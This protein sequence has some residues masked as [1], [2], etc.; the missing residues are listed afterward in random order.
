MDDRG[1]VVVAIVATGIVVAIVVGTVMGTQILHNGTQIQQLAT[2]VAD[3]HHHYAGLLA[4]IQALRSELAA[5]VGPGHIHEIQQDHRRLDDRMHNIEHE[6]SRIDRS[7][8]G[9]PTNAPATRE[10]LDRLRKI[11]DTLEQVNRHLQGCSAGAG[12]CGGRVGHGCAGSAIARESGT[13][14]FHTCCSNGC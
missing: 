3:E 13:C 11:E 4:E 10:S 1:M 14:R 2:H 6:L 7:V 12:R 5:R 8:K 9:L